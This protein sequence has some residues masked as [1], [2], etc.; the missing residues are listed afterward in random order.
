MLVETVLVVV[1][2]VA[3]ALLA[4]QAATLSAL[5]RATDARLRRGDDALTQVI[6]RL[7]AIDAAQKRLEKLSSEV[8]GLS[9]LLGDKR[10]RGAFGEVQ[11]EVLVRNVLPP[12]C[13]AMQPTLS[14]GVRPDCALYLPPP[15]GT[16]AV[17]SKFPLE[18]FNRLCDPDASEVERDA[19]ARAFEVDV[20]RHV[21]D[22][23]SRYLIPGETGECA[24][25]FVPAEAVFAEIHARHPDVVAYAMARRVCIVSPTTMM[26]VLNMARA[27]I[28]DVETREQVHL[29][30]AHLA[31]LA[32]EFERFDA[33]LARLVQHTRQ[34][35]E[36]AGELA[37]AGQRISR[38]FGEIERVELSSD[39]PAA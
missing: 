35:H 14:S 29:I 24:L 18:N 39:E 36:D 22:I 5:S 33:R 37:Q 2:I 26:A 3:V 38:R 6:A 4:W 31:K 23:A 9:Q 19:G 30:R 7:A 20:R 32:K 11:L 12:Q 21:D 17:D 15:T 25:M 13:F 8:V 27:V 1:V 28:K 16:I 10:A 34:A